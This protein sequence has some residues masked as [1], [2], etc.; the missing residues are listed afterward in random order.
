[1]DASARFAA[2]PVNRLLGS[3]LVGRDADRAE[4]ELPLRPD[5]AQ[6]EG[7][8]HGGLIALLADSAAVWLLWPDLDARRA[9][10]SIEFKLNF[11]AAA[12]PDGPPLHAVAV[13]LRIGR[14]VAVC[15]SEVRQGEVLVAKGSFTYLLRDR[16]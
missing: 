9:M 2:T 8:V 10:T 11:L 3:R 6:E 12:R 14:T 1:M 5:F 15:E 7:V 16:A 4:L 13:P